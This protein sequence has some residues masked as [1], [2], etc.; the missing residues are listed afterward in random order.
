MPIL[1]DISGNAAIA[2]GLLSFLWSRKLWW[3][4][5]AVSVLLAFGLVIV[6]GSSTGAGP[7]IYSLF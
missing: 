3:M 4:I 7:F 6:I 2:W 5:P 1:K